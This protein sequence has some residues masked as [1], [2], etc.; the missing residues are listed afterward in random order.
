MLKG[1]NNCYFV[2]LCTSLTWDETSRLSQPDSSGGVKNLG[3]V[4]FQFVYCINF[5]VRICVNL[6]S[7]IF[8]KH[9]MRKAQIKI[10][11]MPVFIND[12]SDLRK[13]GTYSNPN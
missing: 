9:N 2:I 4:A 11:E 3:R 6:I 8:R 12:D 5:L 10:R 7:R 13:P 1:L